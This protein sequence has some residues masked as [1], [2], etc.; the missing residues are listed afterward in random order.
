MGSSI[1]V[2]TFLIANITLFLTLFSSFSHLYC[3]LKSVYYS[4]NPTGGIGIPLPLSIGNETDI[5][6]C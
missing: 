2:V 5:P 6:I 1:L 3:N 4:L